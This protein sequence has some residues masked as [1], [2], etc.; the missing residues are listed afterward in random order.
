VEAKPS[1]YAP[2]VGEWSIGSFPM[3]A[4]STGELG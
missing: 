3:M 1:R 2:K 4:P